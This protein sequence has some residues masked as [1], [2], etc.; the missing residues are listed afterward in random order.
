MN[1]HD[2]IEAGMIELYV[3]GLTDD[4]E[5]RLV[6]AHLRK[7]PGLKRE[8]AQM[9]SEMINYARHQTSQFSGIP[10]A[11]A[12]KPGSTNGSHAQPVP[13]KSIQPGVLLG[14]AALLI[15]SLLFLKRQNFQSIPDN[16]P[17]PP[18]EAQS[19]LLE[20]PA[21]RT[22]SLEGS[23]PD[24]PCQAKLFY[25]EAL[26]QCSLY[27]EVLPTPPKALRYHIWA[28]SNGKTLHA[29][30]VALVLNTFQEL[31]FIPGARSF[32]VTLQ[33]EEAPLQPDTSKLYAGGK[34]YW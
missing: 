10:V 5:T 15:V 17:L 27:L 4:E 7:N 2:F 26:K 21:T 3:L 34:L 18:L 6:E 9:R 12:P 23:N 30:I 25:N 1:E 19:A 13:G 33:P 31:Q 14:V 8:V 29:G 24:N 28:I 16:P 11:P 20:D 22:V 32:F